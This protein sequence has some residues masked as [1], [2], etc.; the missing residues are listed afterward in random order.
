MKRARERLTYANVVSTLALFLVLSGGVALAAKKLTTNDIKKGAIKTK[1]LGKNAVTSAKIASNGVKARNIAADS[2]DGSKVLNGSLT[3]AD[4]L[5]GA[6]VVATASGGDVDVGGGPTP[7]PLSGGAWTQGATENDI[8]AVRLVATLA[9]PPAG[10]CQLTVSLEIE[11]TTVG[12]AGALSG[13]TTPTQIT[14]EALTGVRIASGGPRPSQLK[15]SATSFGF[16]E[17]CKSARIDSLKV[18]VLGVG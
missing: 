3:P 4:L 12:S 5:G 2:I 9:S 7:V 8:F 16:I 18:V 17:P 11:G 1:L 10:V 6:S 14:S 15:A 13:A